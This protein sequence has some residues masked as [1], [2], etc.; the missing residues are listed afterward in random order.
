M[1]QVHPEALR[2][3]DA[4][5]FRTAEALV[6]SSPDEWDHRFDAVLCLASWLLSV[7]IRF[8]RTLEEPQI[9]RSND[10]GQRGNGTDCQELARVDVLH[11][12]DMTD[13][14]QGKNA[15]DRAAH[16]SLPVLHSGGLLYRIEPGKKPQNRFNDRYQSHRKAFRSGS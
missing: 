2:F 7:P 5:M 8:T 12:E 16:Y 11:R 10:S 6:K 1:P 4:T 13:D 9:D 15:I 14:N 3:G